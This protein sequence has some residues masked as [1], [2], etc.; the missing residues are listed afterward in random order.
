M[1]PSQFG[2]MK[3]LATLTSLLILGLGITFSQAD[4]TP[5]SE[6]QP[7]ARKVFQKIQQQS[8]DLERELCAYI[9]YGPDGRLMLTRVA[10]GTEATCILPVRSAKMDV[11]ASLHTHSTYS[12]DYHSEVPSALDMESD[13][14]SGTDGWIATPGG[15]MWFVDSSEMRA[16]QVCGAGCL[17]Q[18]PNFIDEPVGSIKQSYTYSALVKMERY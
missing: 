14:A 8:F 4:D 9:G 15:R 16:Y 13:E 7:F 2:P 3:R 12:P 11:I 10:V 6:I 18:D 5:R 17:P 1:G